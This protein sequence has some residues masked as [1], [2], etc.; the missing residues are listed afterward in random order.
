MVV[1]LA[2]VNNKPCVKIS[3][4]VSKVRFST[5]LPLFVHPFQPFLQNTGDLA[6]LQKVKEIFSL[7]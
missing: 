3:D 2:S 7:S 6:T 4:D 5:P 1:K